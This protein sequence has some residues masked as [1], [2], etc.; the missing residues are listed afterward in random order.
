MIFPLTTVPPRHHT[1]RPTQQCC[2][3]RQP[4]DPRPG[5]PADHPLDLIV[6]LTKRPAADTA[7]KLQ[8]FS[9]RV[10]FPLGN[11]AGDVLASDAVSS[12]RMLQNARFNVHTARV[13]LTNPQTEAV[14]DYLEFGVIPRAAGQLTPLAAV[15][16]LSFVVGQVQVSKVKGSGTVS[17]LEN[18]R[19]QNGSVRAT[20]YKFQDA[21]QNATLVKNVTS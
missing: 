16:D 3:A 13:T 12:A 6:K 8:L 18:W 20:G 11:G 17:V 10:R 14:Q 9:V 7:H 4:P 15:G 2:P 21:R 1:A 19:W 5:S